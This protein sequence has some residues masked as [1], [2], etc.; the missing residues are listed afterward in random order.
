MTKIWRDVKYLWS[1]KCFAVGLPVVTVLSYIT[2]L[3]NPTIGIDDTSFKLYYVD[4]VS[5]AMGRWCLYMINKA[6]PLAT[7]PFFV[8]AVGLCLFCLSVSLWCVVFYRLF[9]DRLPVV[10]YT[11]FCCVMISSPMISE[12]VI[13][14]LQDGIYLGY[15]VTALAVLFGMEALRGEEGER[16]KRQGPEDRGKEKKA[17]PRGQGK[18]KGQSA[19][20]GRKG[21]KGGPVF[22]RALAGRAGWVIASAATLTVALG[23]YEA[24][25][26]VYLMA[27]AMVFLLVRVLDRKDY[28]ARPFVW[29]V[30]V[31]FTVGLSMLLR[32]LV[33]ELITAA[34]HLEAQKL[35]LKSRDAGDILQ[36]AAGWFDGSRSLSEFTYILKDFFVKYYLNA[37]VYTTVLILVLAV[38]MVCLWGLVQTVRKRDGWILAAALCIVLLPWVMPILEAQATYY[39]A[40]EYIPLLTAFAVFP[41]AWELRNRKRPLRAAGL[42]LALLLLYRQGYEMNKWLY[43]DAM[44]YENDKLIMG[45][46]A[47]KIK[48]SCDVSKP[49]CVVGSYQTPRGLIE[50]VYTP[51]WSKKYK[52]LKWLV[53]AVD[54]EIFEKYDTPW[55]YAAAET[56]T[57]SFINWGAVAFYGFDRELV[58]FWKMHGFEFTEDG[59]PEHYAAARDLM[60]DGPVWPQEGSVVEMEDHIIVNFGNYGSGQ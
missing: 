53:C 43:V 18:G 55:G 30:R 24:F 59:N 4:G 51:E 31:I 9:G 50:N 48:E 8:E 21:Q 47:L 56:P 33:I 60:L 38:G 27:M 2:L 11:L 13:W 6:V 23:F 16:K 15:G 19:K 49:V 54:P 44:K 1:R 41:A 3:L 36:M 32:S 22:N 39:R 14:Y 28:T 46:V 10:V 29:L 12:V 26:I 42:C 5:P 40:S 57:L 34:Y 35:V 52:L 58:K 25:M 17:G 45:Q 20:D 37:V 7:N